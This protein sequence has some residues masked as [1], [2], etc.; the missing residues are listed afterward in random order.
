MTKNTNPFFKKEIKIDYKFGI[1]IAIILIVYLTIGLPREINFKKSYDQ[2][3]NEMLI[4]KANIQ[5]KR[6]SEPGITIYI[7]EQ[8]DLNYIWTFI[9]DSNNSRGKEK[10]IYDA[11][12]YVELVLT[13]GTLHY[14]KLFI[15]HDNE[16]IHINYNNNFGQK[17]FSNADDHLFWR[18]MLNL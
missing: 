12:I 5:I 6:I 17:T 16:F 14:L 3:S 11:T 15:D 1:F 4:S 10:K 8:K 18:S 7:T 9:T 13:D 2:F